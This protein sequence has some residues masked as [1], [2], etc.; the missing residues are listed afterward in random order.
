MARRGAVSAVDAALFI[1]GLVVFGVGA[2]TAAML[3]M[4]FRLIPALFSACIGAS[5]FLMFTRPR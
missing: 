1:F 3:P 4:P 5:L 2:M